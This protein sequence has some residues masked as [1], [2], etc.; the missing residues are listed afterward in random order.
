MECTA[1]AHTEVERSADALSLS[2][3]K[4]R[5]GKFLKDVVALYWRCGSGGA[6]P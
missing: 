4:E 3:K 1:N 2:K 5:E 6:E